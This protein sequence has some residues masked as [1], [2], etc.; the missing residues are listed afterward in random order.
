MKLNIVLPIKTIDVN[1]KKIKIPKMGLKHYQL[2]KEVR[3]C[4]DTIKTLLDTICPGLNAAESEMVMLHLFAFNGKIKNTKGDL[5]VDNVYICTENTFTLNGK[6]YTF[7]SPM[8]SSN[9]EIDDAKFLS[10]HSDSDYDFHNFPAFI[11][12]WA[13]GLRKT[14]ALDTPNGTIYGGIN[15]MEALA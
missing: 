15:I 14:V 5:N 2:L 13:K 7:N 6:E 8:L 3:S 9:V 11:M 4:D 12:E 10:M 1:G